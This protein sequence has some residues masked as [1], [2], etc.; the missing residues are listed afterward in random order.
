MKLNFYFIQNQI[1]FLLLNKY[2]NIK[3]Y[4]GF[5]LYLTYVIYVLFL[6]VFLWLWKK[7]KK[8][9]APGKSKGDRAGAWDFS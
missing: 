7:K 4:R 5:L 8:V 1:Q 9:W 2:L 3:F 6:P